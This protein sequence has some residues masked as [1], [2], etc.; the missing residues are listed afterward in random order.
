[1]ADDM[2]CTKTH[3]GNQQ[4][5]TLVE[6]LAILVLVG[7][8]L[9]GVHLLGWLWGTI[10]GVTVFF[11]VASA[12]ALLRDGFEGIPRLPRCRNGCCRG[13][14][15]LP[16]DYG[17]YRIGDEHDLVCRCGIRH[18]R[19]E[20]RF[21]VLKDDGTEVP[22][23]IWRPFRGWFP[24]HGAIGQPDGPANRGQPVGSETNRTSAAAGPGG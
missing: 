8:V 15:L 9:A 4:G 6:M 21:V 12:L 11:L 14:G 19:R 18:K 23:L 3:P 13:P 2:T 24:D 1:M 7:F 10:L 17:D 16:G 20:K 5:F 22:Y